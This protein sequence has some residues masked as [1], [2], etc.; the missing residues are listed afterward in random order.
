MLKAKY[1][2]LK[3]GSFELPFVFS[4][5]SEHAEVARALR[6]EIIGAGFCY[7]NDDSRYTCYG[8]SVSCGFESRGELDAAVLNRKL[9]VEE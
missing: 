3:H 2:V 4:E 6:G 8:R 7:I 5:L 9:G 1:L